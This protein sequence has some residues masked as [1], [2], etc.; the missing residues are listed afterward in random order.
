M[1]KL[2]GSENVGSH[3]VCFLLE[4]AAKFLPSVCADTCT[5]SPGISLAVSAPALAVVSPVDFMVHQLKREEFFCPQE[6]ESTL[7]TEE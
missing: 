2:P 4:E 7:M 1:G 6:Q 3:D 5:R